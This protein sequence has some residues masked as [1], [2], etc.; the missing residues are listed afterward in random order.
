[1]KSGDL[2]AAI[3]VAAFFVLLVGTMTRLTAGRE[4]PSARQKASRMGAI[5]WRAEVY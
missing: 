1:M 3:L 5:T 4:E 2:V